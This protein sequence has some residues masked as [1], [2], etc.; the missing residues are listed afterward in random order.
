[1]S[2]CRFSGDNT[3]EDLMNPSVWRMTFKFLSIMELVRLR[4]V[5]KTFKEKVDLLFRRQEK[6]GIFDSWKE[7]AYNILYSDPRYY[8]PNSL[9]IRL[10]YLRQHLPTLKSLFPSVKL[11]VMNSSKSPEFNSRVYYKLYIEDILDLFVDLESLAI[12]DNIRCRDTNQSYPKLKHLFVESVS[13]AELPSL[14]CLESLGI[15]CEFSELKP[16]LEKNFGRPSKWCEIDFTFSRDSDYLWF[17]SLPSSLEY[18]KF[19]NLF[20]YSRQFKPM[21]PRLM[22]VEY[23][24]E[25]REGNIVDYGHTQFLDFLKDHS[26]TLKKVTMSF[27]SIDD[28]QLKDMLSCLPHGTHLTI[29]TPRGSGHA[30]NVRQYGLIGGLCRD[31]NFYLEINGYSLD[32]LSLGNSNQFLEILPPET[33]SLTL[34][35]DHMA[36]TKA[37]CRKLIRAILASS[38]RLT[39]LLFYPTQETKRRLSTVIQLLPETHEAILEWFEPKPKRVII[40]RRN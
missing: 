11:L 24:E 27:Y 7:P 9:W 4:E 26:D 35:V 12:T 16:W 28:E 17:S 18:F 10:D 19:R 33:Q 40:R 34:Y 5:C 38:L 13:G 37:F 2:L 39:I 3:A 29:A 15:N 30:D 14:P 36:H 20:G 8:V 1:M 32:M 21:F 23:R 25:H 31:R 22:E 6:L